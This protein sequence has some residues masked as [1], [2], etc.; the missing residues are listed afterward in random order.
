MDRTRLDSTRRDSTIRA[1]SAREFDVLVVGGGVIGCGIALDATARGLRTALIEAQD[2]AG[3]TSSR[4]GKV[5]QG[6]LRFPE[7]FDVGLVAETLRERDL[8]AERLAPHLARPEP[9]LMPVRGWWQRGR[10][11][12]TVALHDLVRTGDRGVLPRHRHLGRRRTLAEAPGLLSDELGGAVR[13]HDVSFDDARH[14]L[15][16]ARTAAGLGAT[17]ATRIR[18]VGMLHRAGRV[19]GVRAYDAVGG[20]EVAIQ[21]GVVLNATGV[22]ADRLQALAGSAHRVSVTPLKGVHLVVQAD[23]IDPGANLMIRTREEDLL[24][25]RWFGHWL[26]G[27]PD[28]LTGRDRRAE[29]ALPDDRSEPAEPVVTRRD[30]E[31]VLGQLNRWLRRPIGLDDVITTYAGLRPI[32]PAG[33]ANQFAQPIR[34][35]VIVEDPPG[36][37][38]VV[39][40]TY[41]AYRPIAAEAVD[42]A[43]WRLRRPG[44][45]PS[46]TE[47]LPILGAAGLSTVRARSGAL[48]AESGLTTYWVEH[49]IRRYGATVGELLD[50]IDE[51]PELAEPL[52]G[53]TALA[54]EVVHAARA[55]GAMT[56]EDV[57]VRRTH[58]MLETRDAGQAAAASGARLL[59]S[60]LGWNDAEIDAELEHYRARVRADRAAWHAWSNEEALATY[61]AVRR[62]TGGTRN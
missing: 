53:R 42:L 49:L 50:L 38:T 16:L 35:R 56:L 59:G 58:V 22:W 2:L 8:Q 6:V 9:F 62:G 41:P 17:I 13:Y 54:A 52:P 60:E 29:T 12:G 51:R 48:A 10:V 31:D 47:R 24:V 32:V 14:T 45:P 33:P 61:Q 20:T 21:A 18:A 39:G 37:I 30:I 40:G 28:A 19:R 27:T 57:L 5:V 3:G 1:L 11:G 43:T 15:S 46:G 55:E 44:L 25:R 36:L 34:G 7:R 23:A 26:V 4:S